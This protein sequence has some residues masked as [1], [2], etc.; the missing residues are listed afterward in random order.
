M[1]TFLLLIV[2]CAC[3]QGKAQNVYIQPEAGC[4]IT[5]AH[6]KDNQF[7]PISTSG[8]GTYHFQVSIGKSFGRVVLCTGLSYL[9][10]GFGLNIVESGYISTLGYGTNYWY[11]YHLT[12]PLYAGYTFNIGKTIKLVPAIGP[13]VSYNLSGVVQKEG[14]QTTTN[15]NNVGEY[16]HPMSIFAA[17]RVNA[18][19]CWSKQF[20]I[21]IAP[22][23]LYSLTNMAK[24]PGHMNSPEKQHDHAY[25]LNAGIKWRLAKRD[26]S[27]NN[28]K[29][30][31]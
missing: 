12:L 20:S 24:T 17:A 31:K 23:A 14:S 30:G 4:G 9:R 22:E 11:Y 16:Y 19:F 26:K 13:E 8:I 25:L 18:E 28:D 6:I 29:A 15:V 3:L 21:V 10:T 7:P 27:S 2:V 1:R 5:N